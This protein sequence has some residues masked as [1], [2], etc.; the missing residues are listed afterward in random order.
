MHPILD[1]CIGVFL[2]FDAVCQIPMA[3]ITQENEILQ[4]VTASGTTEADVVVLQGAIR[5]PAPFTVRAPSPHARPLIH[6]RTDQA[7]AAWGKSG[8]TF[9]FKPHISSKVSIS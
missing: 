2:L 1:E 6:Q 4:C 5:P 8:F 3:H 7:I 9:T